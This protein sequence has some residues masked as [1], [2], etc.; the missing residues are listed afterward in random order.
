MNAALR[1][2]ARVCRRNGGVEHELDAHRVAGVGN[3]LEVSRLARMVVGDG[4]A[5]NTLAREAAI[6]HH[7]RLVVACLTEFYRVVR[8]VKALHLR[9]AHCYLRILGGITLCGIPACLI[10]EAALGF[11][12]HALFRFKRV[13][14]HDR[15]VDVVVLVS[16]GAALVIF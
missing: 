15:C 9:A 4:L 5:L 14:V 16:V 7:A 2:A 8:V 13:G 10:C 12:A 11:G 6:G 3:L 1:C